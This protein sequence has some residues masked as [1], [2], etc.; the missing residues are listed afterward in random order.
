MK[1]NIM[2]VDDSISVL[3]CIPWLFKGEPYYIFTLDNPLDALNVIKTLEWA[4]VVAERYMRNMD[5][6]EF[7]KKFKDISPHTMGIIMSGYDEFTEPLDILY[8]ECVYRFVKKPL[9]NVE[10][11]HAVSD[12]V[13]Y[14]NKMQAAKGY[15]IKNETQRTNLI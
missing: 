3:E 8:P 5:G 11:K 9:D 2:F 4:V 12:A 13:T 7:L 10:I 14:Y 1:P 15:A 6:L